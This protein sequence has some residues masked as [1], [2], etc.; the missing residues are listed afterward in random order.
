MAVLNIT[1]SNIVLCPL[2]GIEKLM[3]E[4]IENN[5]NIPRLGI[6]S[7]WKIV[8]IIRAMLFSIFIV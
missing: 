4:F 8:E 1:I 3:Y 2:A 7:G 5:K 6:T